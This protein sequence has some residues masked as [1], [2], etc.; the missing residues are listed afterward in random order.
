MFGNSNPGQSIIIMKDFK[1]LVKLVKAC[2]TYSPWNKMQTL[3]TFNKELLS[4]VKEVNVA[5]RN[6]NYK[7]LKEELGDVVWDAM[8][9]AHIAEEKGYF[10]ADDVIKEVNKKFKNRKPFIVKKRAVSLAE[11]VNVWHKAKAREKRR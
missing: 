6:K 3:E 2:R 4:E 9:M 1:E 11:E 7:N 5:I 10:R 8:M